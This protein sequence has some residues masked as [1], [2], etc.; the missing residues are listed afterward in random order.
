MYNEKQKS[1]ILNTFYNNVT[2]NR[3]ANLSSLDLA[4]I[5]KSDSVEKTK[6]A[7]EKIQA[8]CISAIPEGVPVPAISLYITPSSLD[9]LEGIALATISVTNRVKA[10][11]K[12]K[13]TYVAEQS[14]PNDVKNVTDFFESVYS[15]LIEDYLAE[16]N[17]KIVNQVLAE[18]SEKA[19]VPYRIEVVTALGQGNKVLAYA[20]DDKVVYVADA[21]RVFKLDD[22]LALQ[23]ITE[24]LLEVEKTTIENAKEQIRDCF[25]TAQTSAQAIASHGGVLI[26]YLCNLSARKKALNLV[27]KLGKDVDKITTSGSKDGLFIYEKDNV[28]A[29]IAREDGELKV[30]LSPF[31][32]ETYKNVDKD[33]LAEIA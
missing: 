7:I 4:S 11:K 26:Q 17:L 3:E 29:V 13:Y 24:D 19:E 16:E 25:S 27:K 33:V 1:E 30:A 12:F 23:P 20:S 2:K 21:E 6:E 5:M 10:T 14:N 9:G 15:Q 28:C 31:D 32:T 22:I 18:E 8:N